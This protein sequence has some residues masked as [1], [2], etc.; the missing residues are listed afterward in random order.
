MTS[1]K[2]SNRHPLLKKPEPTEYL[3]VN[4]PMPICLLTLEHLE[5]FQFTHFIL[6]Q[7]NSYKCACHFFHSTLTIKQILTTINELTLMNI[8]CFPHFHGPHIIISVTHNHSHYVITQTTMNCVT[9][10]YIT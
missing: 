9:L 4:I 6:T 7:K 2:S 5:R 10:D 1:S 3:N 8:P